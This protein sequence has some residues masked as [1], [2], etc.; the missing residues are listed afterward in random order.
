MS[1]WIKITRSLPRRGKK[2]VTKSKESEDTILYGCVRKVRKN[3]IN[4]DPKLKKHEPRFVKTCEVVHIPP[5]RRQYSRW[6][7]KKGLAY[8]KRA[9]A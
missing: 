1:H 2:S 9:A 8:S 4:I 6:C 5:T 7:N 3:I